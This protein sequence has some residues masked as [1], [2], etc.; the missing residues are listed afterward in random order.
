[1]T[2]T[3]GKTIDDDFIEMLT[4]PFDISE[5]EFYRFCKANRDW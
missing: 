1:M 4:L 3:L 2:A 5:E